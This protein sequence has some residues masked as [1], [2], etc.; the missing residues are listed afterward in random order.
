MRE[1]YAKFVLWLI[2]PALDMHQAKYAA[3]T[4]VIW[5]PIWRAELKTELEK[6]RA[7]MLD[8]MQRERI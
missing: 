4:S 8:Q 5:P 3:K 1:L 2:R 7:L 6:E